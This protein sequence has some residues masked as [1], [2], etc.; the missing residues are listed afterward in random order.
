MDEV[1]ARDL[2]NHTG[3]VLRRVEGGAHVRITVNR[4]PVAELRPAATRSGWVS[5]AVMEEVLRA[6][7][8]DARLLED[9]APLREQTVEPR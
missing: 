3:E 4:R 6:A 5:G 7:P 8:A 1:P 9:L 2:R